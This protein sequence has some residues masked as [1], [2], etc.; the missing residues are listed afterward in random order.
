MF[1]DSWMFPDSSHSG[2]SD[3]QGIYTTGEF[4]FLGIQKQCFHFKFWIQKNFR[5]HDETG[6]FWFRTHVFWVNGKRI[7]DQNVPQDSSRIRKH[8]LLKYKRS[9]SS[10]TCVR[11]CKWWPNRSRLA[12]SRKSQ[13]FAEIMHIQ[14][15]WARGKWFCFL[16]AVIGRLE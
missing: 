8:H 11:T 10:W 6:K 7:Q 1:P 15:T 14:M 16:Q 12:S 13:K 3:S 9:L 5:I 4:G 2:Y